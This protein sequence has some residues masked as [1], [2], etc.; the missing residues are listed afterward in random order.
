MTVKMCSDIFLATIAMEIE[1]SFCCSFPRVITDHK[2]KIKG[3]SIKFPQTSEFA[4]VVI[5]AKIQMIEITHTVW[6]K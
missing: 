2:K 6:L 3:K 1:V 4:K 5:T